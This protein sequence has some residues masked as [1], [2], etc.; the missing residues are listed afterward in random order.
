MSHP[1]HFR[2]R[3]ARLFSLTRMALTA[4][5]L[6]VPLALGL[7]GN[8]QAAD[9]PLPII[10]SIVPQ[11]Y[12]LERIAGER[13]AVSVL[14]RP[15]ADPHSYEPGPAQMRAC[16][17]ARVWFTIGVPFE[18]VWLPRIRSAAPNLAVI[19]TI[20]HIKRLRFADDALL[21]A[22]LELAHKD[23][24]PAASE[25]GQTPVSSPAAPHPPD[26][27]AGQRKNSAEHE[28]H[29]DHKADGAEDPHVWLSPMLVRDMLPLMAKEL[30]KLQPEHATEFRANAEK[31]AAELEE[32]DERLAGRFE[33]FSREKRV[34]LTFHP[35]W[36]YFAHNYGLTELAIEMEGKE[37]GPQGMKAVINVARTYGI[38]TIFV[39]PQ[40]PKAA[41][42]AI[43]ANIG[44]KVVEVDP[45]AE[46]LPG[47]YNDLADKLIES[48][49]Q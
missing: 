36:R 5:L 28:E 33:E 26:V 19:S 3:P 25:S 21:L 2:M 15:G 32:L 17:S 23:R 46:N 11:K 4:F 9:A 44:A 13:V 49:K 8:A 35:S 29:H 16:A 41:A 47:T 27:E 40:F 20:A 1:N 39:E 48:F 14:V 6:L 38:R 30:G 12:M 7:A 18:D 42:Q 31:F 34:F 45:L 24:T 10:V 37:P 43:A 22:D